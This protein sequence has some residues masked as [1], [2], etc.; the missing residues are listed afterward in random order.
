MQTIKDRCDRVSWLDHGE[1]KFIGEP[2]EA[3][4]HYRK[5]QAN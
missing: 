2:E 5:S 1:I 4:N 3:I